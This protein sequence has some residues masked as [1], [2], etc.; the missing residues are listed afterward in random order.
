MASFLFSDSCEQPRKYFIYLYL[1]FAYL[2]LDCKK[3]SGDTETFIQTQAFLV[4]KMVKNFPVMQETW[5]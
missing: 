5:V 4:A 2:S 1:F 3:S